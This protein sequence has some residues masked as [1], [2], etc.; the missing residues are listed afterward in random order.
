MRLVAHRFVVDGFRGR[1]RDRAKT[2]SSNAAH[3]LQSLG[4]FE[5]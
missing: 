5:V 4:V 1:D 2:V 3:R